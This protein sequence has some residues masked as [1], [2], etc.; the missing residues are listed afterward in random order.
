M[1]KVDPQLLPPGSCAAFEL[2]VDPGRLA[3]A[4]VDE[5]DAGEADVKH[6]GNLADER[7]GDVERAPRPAEGVRELGYDLELA[8]CRGALAARPA[9]FARTLAPAPEQRCRRFFHW[10]LRQMLRP[11]FRDCAC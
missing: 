1:A 6:R 7:A 5:H 8:L 9:A 3:P 4:L 11:E 10:A 2:A